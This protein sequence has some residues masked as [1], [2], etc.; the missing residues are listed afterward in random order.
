MRV[1]ASTGALQRRAV[2][3]Y[4]SF[5]PAMQRY[6]APLMAQNIYDA[7]SARAAERSADAVI[8]I[9]TQRVTRKIALHCIYITQTFSLLRHLVSFLNERDRRHAPNMFDEII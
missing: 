2:R 3:A 4:V 5:E 7:A 6:V 8:D 9:R 1:A